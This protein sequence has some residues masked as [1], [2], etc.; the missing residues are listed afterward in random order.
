MGPGAYP[1]WID[2]A[3]G[4]RF[5]PLGRGPVPYEH[6]YDFKVIVTNNPLSAKNV[7]N[8]H[9]GRGAQE[10]LF[11]ELKSQIQMDYV[12]TRKQAADHDYFFDRW[13]NKLGS[14]FLALSRITEPRKTPTPNRSR[15]RHRSIAHAGRHA[16]RSLA[17]SS[18]QADAGYEDCHTPDSPSPPAPRPG[19]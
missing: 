12:S 9:N 7:L 13:R 4:T 17:T 6:G 8:Y 1:S 15:G 16:V 5:Q 11:A 14:G 3:V 2:D 10:G 18:T 19:R